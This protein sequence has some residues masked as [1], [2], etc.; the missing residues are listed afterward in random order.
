M[1]YQKYFQSL[2]KDSQDVY[3][4]R[5]LTTG[6]YLRTHIFVPKI[7]RKIPRPDLIERLAEASNGNVSMDDVLSFLYKTEIDKAA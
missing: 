5:A 6:A 4:S 3:A 7:R 1:N 2:N